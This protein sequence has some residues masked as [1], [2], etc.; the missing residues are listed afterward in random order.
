MADLAITGTVT[1][2][3]LGLADL[4][5]NTDAYKIIEWGPGVVAQARMK[6]GSPYIHGD[7][8]VA[9]KKE[10]V[11]MPLGVRVTGSTYIDCW[12]K[13]G[14]LLRAFEQFAFVVTVVQDGTTFQ[15]TCESADY[16]VGEGGIVQKFHMMA[17]KQEVRFLIPR[18]PNPTTGPV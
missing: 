9:A 1:R 11:E 5:L 16:A 12:N 4:G 14:T 18:R 8:L 6:V 13:V 2:T 10:Q 15:Y 17:Y 7:F 3:E